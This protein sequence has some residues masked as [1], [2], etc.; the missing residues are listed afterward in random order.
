M[1]NPNDRLTLRAMLLDELMA[2]K[3][4][5]ENEVKQLNSKVAEQ[6]KQISELEAAAKKPRARPSRRK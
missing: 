1:M 3:T 5:L 4:Q 6:A 2:Q